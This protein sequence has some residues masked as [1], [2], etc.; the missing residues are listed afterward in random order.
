MTIKYNIVIRVER[1][2]HAIEQNILVNVR[3]F[4]LIVSC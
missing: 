1:K 2:Y 3:E 4:E